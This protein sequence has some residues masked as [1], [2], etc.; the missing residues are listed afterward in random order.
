VTGKGQPPRPAA[1]AGRTW[2]QAIA[3]YCR[4]G[5]RKM[6]A[7]AACSC[8]RRPPMVGCRVSGIAQVVA[9]ACERA[10]LP[11]IGTHRFTP[12]R[13]HRHAR[14]LA[15][16]L[17]ENRPKCCGIDMSRR[18]PC[19]PRT[20]SRPLAVVARPWP[21]GGGMSAETSGPELRTT[22]AF[23]ERWAS[24]WKT[25]AGCCPAFVSYPRAHPAHRPSPSRPRWDGAT[26]PPGVQPYRWKQRLSVVRG[27]ARY[28]HAPRPRGAGAAERP[29]CL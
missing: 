28:L 12:Q 11:R 14:P 15:R 7:A 21:G 1:V 19:M 24:S 17:F 29:A 6:A 27:F 4:D 25:T 26:Q 5:R 9:R 2:G 20:T 23:D 10:G 22:S 13:G 16:P 8:V 3:D 18:Q